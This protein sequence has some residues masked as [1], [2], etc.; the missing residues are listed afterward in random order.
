MSL[1]Q[2]KHQTL[3]GRGHTCGRRAQRRAGANPQRH[4]PG[5]PASSRA[6]RPGRG[7]GLSTSPR[8]HA[9][10]SG[11]GGRGLHAGP[12][13]TSRSCGRPRDRGPVLTGPAHP[14]PG[15]RASSTSRR[16]AGPGNLSQDR[17]Q[18]P[19]GAA[20]TGGDR[21]ASASQPGTS[22]AECGRRRGFGC[23]S[24]AAP[25]PSPPQW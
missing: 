11:H 15:L 21:V 19:Q 1:C 16:P 25:S 3:R 12:L 23:R 14:A 6:P 20:R 9:A 2:P 24:P 5:Q 8:L 18:V 13:G 10:A 7:S 4:A 17:Y 22:V